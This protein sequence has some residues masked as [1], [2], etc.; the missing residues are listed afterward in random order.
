MTSARDPAGQAAVMRDWLRLHD[1]DAVTCARLLQRPVTRPPAPECVQPSVPSRVSGASGPAALWELVAQALA[2]Q[3][4]ALAGRIEETATRSMVNFAPDPA[5][6]PRPFTLYLDARALVYVSCP[7]P[8]GGGGDV[9]LMA[10]EFGH[11]LQ[12]HC[13]PGAAVPPVMRETCAFLAEDLV[14]AGLRDLA[15]DLAQSAHAE[16]MRQSRRSLGPMRDRL[17]ACLSR[18][19][20]PYAYDWNYPPARV[21]AHHLSAAGLPQQLE[22]MFYARTTPGAL[23]GQM[24]TGA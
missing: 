17:V 1:L 4:P 21:F 6:H 14:I 18:P 9:L 5:R 7:L 16:L 2:G 23:L 13:V 12:L 20:K 15:P 8:G 10:H 11:A 3:L 22:A 19:D 24:E